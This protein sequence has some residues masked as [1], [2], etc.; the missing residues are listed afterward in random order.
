MPAPRNWNKRPTRKA[1]Q[2]RQDQAYWDQTGAKGDEAGLR[3]YVKRYPDG[4]FADLAGQRLAAIEAA[5]RD[6]AAARDRGEWDRATGRNTEAAYTEYLMALPDGAFA[7]EAK[8]R[9][10]MLQLQA[11]EG[12]DRARWQQ[13][14]DGLLLSPMAR[15]LIEARLEALDFGPGPADGVFDDQTRRAIRR[16]QAARDLAST[17]YLD[18][19]T[20]VSLL[21]DGVLKLGE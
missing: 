6:Q 10:E 3:A 21:A 19:Q 9:I 2:E 18:Q 14:E 11:A 13:V 16:F 15:R 20:M 5:A 12:D 7:E 4:Q 8:S 1:D 17:G